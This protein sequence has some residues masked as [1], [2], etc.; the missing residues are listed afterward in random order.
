MSKSDFDF[1][2]FENYVKKFEKMTTEFDE[3][4]RTFLLQQ[5]QR[6][7]SN[8]KRR[9]PVDTGAMRASWG[10]GSQKITLTKI[11]NGKSV[12][13][14]PENSTIADISVVGNNFEVEIWN[15]VEYASYIEWGHRTRGGNGWVEGYYVLTISIQQVENAMPARFNS[16]FT[17]FLK[18]RGV[19]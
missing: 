13:I 15:S 14:D 17:K 12:K 11:G 1:R 4:L 7:V 3:F 5:A 6:V 8:A 16:T 10:I 18:E 9:T 19:G 2:Q